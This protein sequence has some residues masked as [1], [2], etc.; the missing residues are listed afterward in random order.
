MS[1]DFVAGPVSLDSSSMHKEWV[2]TQLGR[3]VVEN[4]VEVAASVHGAHIVS[5]IRV[6]LGAW[7]LEQVVQRLGHYLRCAVHRLH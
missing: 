2:L 3:A 5:L 7:V 6:E 4:A 1:V